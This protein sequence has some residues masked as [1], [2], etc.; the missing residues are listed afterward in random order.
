VS[1]AWTITAGLVLA[2]IIVT[3]SLLFP[4]PEWLSRLLIDPLAV[5]W[6]D[7]PVRER[8]RQ[9]R[10]LLLGYLVFTAAAAVVVVVWLLPSVL[11]RHPPIADA[12][13]R[14]KAITDTR[15]SLAAVLAAAGAAGGLAYTARTY[16]LSREGQVT[17]RYSKAVEL[18]GN[19]KPE[20]RLGGIY[21]LERLMR[22]SASDQPTI[23]ETLAV[24]VRQHAP[25]DLESL[26]RQAESQ[27]G[28]PHRL[29]EDVQAI[30]TVL[31]R[32]RFVNNEG[33]ISLANTN[34]TGGRLN[35]AR[36]S[37]ADLSGADL[38]GA[39]LSGASLRGAN[40]SGANLTG[41]HLIE[42]RLVDANLAGAT[43]T[44][45]NLS[46]ANIGR[47]HLTVGALSQNQLTKATNVD[48]IDWL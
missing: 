11:T 21:A 27:V 36:L 30:L 20:V 43:L 23:M 40:L 18:L 3:G 12:A 10:T 13:E 33:E 46:Q 5:Y 2:F 45:A 6:H 31:S 35:R 7:E 26:P 38:T 24:Y 34:L 28:H 48:E 47:A 39:D 25:R 8:R 17:E 16:R 41:A 14:H 32:R 4:T 19:D 29:A 42:T 22:D 15:T 44:D 9:R 1:T 37:H